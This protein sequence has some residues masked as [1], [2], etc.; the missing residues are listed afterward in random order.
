[1]AIDHDALAAVERDAGFCK[2]KAIG[3][4]RAA[5]GDQHDV[6]VERFGR[7]AGRRFERG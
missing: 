5:D 1:M 4:G 3:V 7:A 6:G 2:A